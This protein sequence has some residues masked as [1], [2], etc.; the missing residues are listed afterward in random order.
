MYKKMIVAGLSLVAFASV[1]QAKFKVD[2]I[3]L[4]VGNSAEAKGDFSEGAFG[5]KDISSVHGNVYIHE[6]DNDTLTVRTT[7]IPVDV[8]FMDRGVLAKGGVSNGVMNIVNMSGREIRVSD[9]MGTYTG[10]LAGASII[11]DLDY[12]VMM[13][14]KGIL[15][16]DA[17][18]GLGIGLRGAQRKV[19]I[20][21]TGSG[22]SDIHVSIT[23]AG[24]STLS[25]QSV[26][27]YQQALTKP[28]N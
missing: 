25:Q 26:M 1:A 5:F 17:Q 23:G 4:Y 19:L 3:N 11:V 18:G 2:T 20:L 14:D 24:A 22:I 9:L 6:S 15:L 21:P 13:N 28:L 12:S 16:T 8:R 10:A 27:T 7:F